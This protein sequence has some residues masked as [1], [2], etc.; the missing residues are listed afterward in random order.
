MWIKKGQRCTATHSDA[1]QH[2]RRTGLIL[3]DQQRNWRLVG[4]GLIFFFGVWSFQF[5]GYW[6]NLSRRSA[7]LAKD[8]IETN[9]GRPRVSIIHISPL[10]LVRPPNFFF[11]KEINKKKKRPL[12]C[13]NKIDCYTGQVYVFF[14]GQCALRSYCCLLESFSII[15]KRQRRGEK[16]FIMSFPNFYGTAYR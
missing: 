5:R 3:S 13:T 12:T 15:Q 11:L 2:T 1:Q 9:K 8:D 7:A 16:D 10:G 4:F 14:L 6:E